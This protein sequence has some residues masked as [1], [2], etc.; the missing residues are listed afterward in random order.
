MLNMGIDQTSCSFLVMPS[1]TLLICIGLV[2]VILGLGLA[3]IV[4]AICT[5]L[6]R[7]EQYKRFLEEETAQTQRKQEQE[8]AFALR[9][10]EQEAIDRVMDNRMLCLVCWEELHPG[11]QF[12]MPGFH[13]CDDHYVQEEVSCTDMNQYQ[14]INPYSANQSLLVEEV[15]V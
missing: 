15:Y 2:G 11:M 1:T 4:M 12:P 10:Q 7:R 6:Q 9:E 13:F 5:Q 8:A 14:P 3:Q